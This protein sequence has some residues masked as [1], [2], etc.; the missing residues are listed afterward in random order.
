MQNSKLL[1]LL[2]DPVLRQR[3]P[4]ELSS[5]LLCS[6]DAVTALCQKARSV[7]FG[8]FFSTALFR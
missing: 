7:E 4:N 8:V 1:A 2:H 5:M 6:Q 3:H